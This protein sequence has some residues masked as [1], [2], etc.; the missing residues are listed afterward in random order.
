MPSLKKHLLKD[1][2]STKFS[3]QAVNVPQGPENM[4]KK[5]FQ[6]T[7]LGLSVYF[8]ISTLNKR[9]SHM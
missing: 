6:T 9:A 5:R 2:L 8:F 3:M 1:T 7:F 4:E